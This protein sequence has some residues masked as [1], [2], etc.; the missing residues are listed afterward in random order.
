MKL[1]WSPR[2]PFVRKALIAAHETDLIPEIG[3][4]VGTISLIAEHGVW[5]RDSGAE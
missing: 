5:L 4:I 1:Y 2:S 3:G